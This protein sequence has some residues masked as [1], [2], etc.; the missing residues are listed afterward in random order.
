MKIQKDKSLSYSGQLHQKPAKRETS[1]KDL[2][3]P[4]FD[5]RLSI[6]E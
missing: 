1:K 3:L 5:N 6:A 2:N 4:P